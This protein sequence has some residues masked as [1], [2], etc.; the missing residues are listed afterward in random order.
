MVEVADAG[1]PVRL[2]ESSYV[3]DLSR[4]LE[5]L[6]ASREVRLLRA[7]LASLVDVAGHVPL[8]FGAWHGDWTPWNM[9]ADGARLMLWDWEH[10]EVDVPAGF[11]ALHLAVNSAV[12][13]GSPV[14]AAVR[15][16][17]E[18]SSDLLRPFQDAGAAAP[19]TVL[20]YVVHLASRYLEDGEV[21][22]GTTLGDLPTWLEPV[23]ADEM[24]ALPRRLP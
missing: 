17:Q 24:D 16:A 18:G 4:R 23:L 15:D 22:A 5:V 7:A 9:A 19:L 3:V 20:L 10:Y 11:D 1:D 6:Q 13:N 14:R 12:R 21:E 8:R 2:G